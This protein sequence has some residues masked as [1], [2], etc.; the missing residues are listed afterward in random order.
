MEVFF[1]SSTLTMPGISARVAIFFG[2][3]ASNNSLNTREA[4]RDIV[5][6][7][8]AV[9]NVRMVSCVPGSPMDWAAMTPTASPALTGWPM[10]R[11]MP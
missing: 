5:A 1:V 10:A 7:D 3:R 4:L 11:L 9:W 2:L 8:A 6:G